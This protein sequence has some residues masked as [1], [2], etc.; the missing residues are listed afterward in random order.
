MSVPPMCARIIRIHLSEQDSVLFL[1]LFYCCYY[2][3]FPIVF[4]I[5]NVMGK[6]LT[7]IYI[8]SISVALVYYQ[9]QPLH[10]SAK[11]ISLYW[12]LLIIKHSLFIIN[13]INGSYFAKKCQFI[14]A[15]CC[16]TATCF[17]S[18]RKKGNLE[19]SKQSLAFSGLQICA[20]KR[21]I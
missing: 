20:W 16:C 12:I 1:I 9:Y 2:S 15:Y 7:S 8:I 19:D 11:V 13:I 21:W 17:P 3:F 4:G 6:T 5:W 18:N 14:K 10:K